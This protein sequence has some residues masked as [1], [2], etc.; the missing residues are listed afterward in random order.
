MM[1]LADY[2]TSLETFGIKLGL[3]QTAEL[4]NRADCRIEKNK[5]PYFSY[6]AI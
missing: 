5:K 4:M 6:H 2:L 1:K 3:A